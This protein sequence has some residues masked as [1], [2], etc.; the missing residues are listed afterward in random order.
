MKH[1]PD[2]W[3]A[4]VGKTEGDWRPRPHESETE[5]ACLPHH[6]FDA[7]D[8]FGPEI[9]RVLTREELEAN[10]CLIAA[11]PELLRAVKSAEDSLSF[12]LNHSTMN[13]SWFNKFNSVL[14]ECRVSISKAEGVK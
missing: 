13:D 6:H 3:R 5:I 8:V 14:Q 2:P 9:D 12:F 11:S 10:A 4:A 1:S 7:I